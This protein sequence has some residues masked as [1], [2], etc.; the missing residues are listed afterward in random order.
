MM[1]VV[2]RPNRILAIYFLE[3]LTKLEFDILIDKTCESKDQKLFR[4]SRMPFY[5]RQGI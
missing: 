2:D 4:Y 5:E 1:K 3:I